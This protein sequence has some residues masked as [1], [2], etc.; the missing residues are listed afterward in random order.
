MRGD[1][2]D[3]AHCRAI[4]DE[5][6]HTFGGIDVLVNNAA[7]QMTFRTLED[8]PDEEWERTFATNIHAMFYL[9]KA[10]LPHMGE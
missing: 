4:I 6:A 9:A 10:A 1:I 2:S 3:A 7:H 5:A 8:I